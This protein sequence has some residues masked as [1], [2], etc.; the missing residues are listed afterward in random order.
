MKLYNSLTNEY[1]NL[2]TI[3]NNTINWYC[4]G[5]TIYNDSHLGHART[6][7]IFDSMIRFLRLQ[8]YTINYGMNITDID[9][10]IINKVNQM[11]SDNNSSLTKDILYKSF[12]KNQEQRFWN[13]LSVLNVDKP[14]Q[15]L[16]V[17]DTIPDLIEFINILI[18]KKFAYVGSS[19]SINKSIYFDVNI[20]SNQ[21]DK[22]KL[23]MSNENDIQI[24]NTHIEDKNDAKDFALWKAVKTGEISWDSGKL[25]VGMGRPGWHIECSVMMNKMFGNQVDIHSGGIDL[26][27]PHHHNEFCQTTSYYSDPKWIKCFVH[28][29]H[30]HIDGEKMSQ[31]LG[32]FITIKKFLELYTPNEIRLMF[33]SVKY[34]Q[35]MDLNDQ[36]I[37]YGQNMNKR[38]S[39]F[40]NNLDYHIKSSNSSSLNYF[41][42]TKLN[43]DLVQVLNN[44]FD[45]PEALKLLSQSID[46]INKTNFEYNN[47]D[48]IKILFSTFLSGLGLVYQK[49]ENENWSDNYNQ[50]IETI[51]EI[52][53]EIKQ[54]AL[55]ADKPTKVNLFK[56]SD[57]IRDQYM[58]NLKIKL[59]DLP[60]NKVKWYVNK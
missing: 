34:N 52:R 32:N 55:T 36:I 26:K 30:L 48:Q 22:T 43:D 35:Q 9:D 51:I 46:Q 53:K 23:D 21:F 18:S 42:I 10:K 58:P 40:I 4:C 14:D 1:F 33:L 49:V 57:K 3:K 16:R 5:P 24:K 45:T 25:N 50:I 47:L 12:I 11:F 6:Y 17:T 31:S 56:L 2:E 27:Y 29:G 13:D 15:I 44:D 41:D 59:E 38:F 19:E 20:Y 60:D 39:N 28:S 37:K 8:D 54:L 7:I